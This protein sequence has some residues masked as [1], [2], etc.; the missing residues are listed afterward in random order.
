MEENLIV[1][2]RAWEKSMLCCLM[3]LLWATMFQIIF[4]KDASQI[5]RKLVDRINLLSGKIYAEKI[6]LDTFSDRL[7]MSSYLSPLSRPE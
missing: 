6:F 4:N 7:I 3:M 5:Y 1:E 2:K